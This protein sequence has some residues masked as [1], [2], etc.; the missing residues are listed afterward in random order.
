MFLLALTSLSI[1]LLHS[2]HLYISEEP[3]LFITPQKVH[4]F[5]VYSRRLFMSGWNPCQLQ[6]MVL[7]PC[8]VSYQ[9]YVR[10]GKFLDCSMYQRSGDLFLGVPFNIASTSLLVYIIANLCSLQPGKVIITIGDAHIY[11]EHVDA[12]K[13]QLQR[14]PLSLPTLKIHGKLERIEDI[15][16]ENIEVVNYLSYPTIKAKMVV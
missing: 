13:I 7:H 8:H 12:V 11:Q 14:I 10:Q 6:Q 2:L 16:Y 15:Q 5:D 3:T 9:F 4:V 1:T